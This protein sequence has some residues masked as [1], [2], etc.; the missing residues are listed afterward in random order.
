MLSGWRRG[1]AFWRQRG[2]K[3]RGGPVKHTVKL[4][5]GKMI[6]G[7]SSVDLERVEQG[8]ESR[9][10]VGSAFL[11]SLRPVWILGAPWVWA[12]RRAVKTLAAR[13]DWVIARL[14]LREAA[15]T[16]ETQ[17]WNRGKQ[18]KRK[19]CLTSQVFGLQTKTVAFL[20]RLCAIW[21]IRKLF[22]CFKSVLWH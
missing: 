21:S 17:L 2:G 14:I 5:Q 19:S 10:K 22:E 16:Y 18:E 4:I 15:R 8:R 20:Q 13:W 1:A 6:L 12:P 7:W 9:Q 11:Y 3:Q